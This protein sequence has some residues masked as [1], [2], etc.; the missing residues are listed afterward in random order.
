[1][2]DFLQKLGRSGLEIANGFG[3]AGIIFW[4]AI[5]GLPDF[6]NGPALLIRQLYFVGVYSLI[7]IIVSGILIGMVLALQGYTVLVRFGAEVEIPLAG[8]GLLVIRRGR[9]LNEAL[10][11]TRCFVHIPTGKGLLGS[12]RKPLPTDLEI[13]IT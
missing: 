2:L 13:R 4:Q 3:R 9:V 5:W 7:I 6:R 11:L 8:D 10:D 1:M 12:E